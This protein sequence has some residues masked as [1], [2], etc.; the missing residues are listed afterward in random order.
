MYTCICV[1]IY[2]YIEREIYVYR[3]IYIWVWDIYGMRPPH[4][5]EISSPSFGKPPYEESGLFIRTT[6]N[7]CLLTL[8]AV[9]RR[10]VWAM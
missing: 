4:G 6:V 7:G 3:Y 8:A 10:V 9:S 2:I 5:N 1:Y